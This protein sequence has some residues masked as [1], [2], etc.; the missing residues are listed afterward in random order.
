M[1]VDSWVLQASAAADA[2]V[3]AAE[4]ALR[5]FRICQHLLQ[6]CCDEIRRTRALDQEGSKAEQLQW[7]DEP[8]A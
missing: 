3:R 4:K 7:L 8:G 1:T 2:G 6:S 5:E